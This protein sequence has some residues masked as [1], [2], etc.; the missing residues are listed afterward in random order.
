M[1][2]QIR[3]METHLK[4]T[5]QFDAWGFTDGWDEYCTLSD[6]DGIFSSQYISERGGKFLF[7]EMKHWDG[8]GSRPDVDMNMFSGQMVMLKK[9]SAV[10]GFTVVL[11]FGDAATQTVYDFA[12]V[13]NSKTNPLVVDSKA[14]DFKQF[15]SD[16]WVYASTPIDYGVTK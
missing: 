6:V 8:S 2:H 15:L 12:L 11:G 16:W 1:V 10:E 4:N 3:S 9:L 7:I 13:S 14:R 5:W